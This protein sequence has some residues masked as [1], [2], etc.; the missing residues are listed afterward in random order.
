LPHWLR[1]EQQVTCAQLLPIL[2]RFHCAMLADPVGSG[3]TWVALG[4]AAV[5][6]GGHPTVALVPAGIQSQWVSAAA[7]AGVPLTVWSHERLS[8]GSLPSEL[9]HRVPGALVIVDESH[10]FRNGSTR[11]YRH[12]A[13][14]LMERTVLLLTATPMVNRIQD[15]TAQLALGARDDALGDWGIESLRTHLADE[16]TRSSSLSELI[17]ASQ[18]SPA[19]RPRRLRRKEPA[20]PDDRELLSRCERIDRLALS[21][22]NAT[23]ALIR[24]IIWRALASSDLALLG[25][26]R[27]YRTL[28]HQARDAAL[29]GRV[30]SRASLKSLVG[31]AED[32]LV[33]WGLFPQPVDDS[34]LIM[35]DLELLDQLIDETRRMA[36]SGDAKSRR[37]AALVGDGKSTVVFTG[38]RE[39][40]HYLR[41]QIPR[42]A[43]CTG[44]AA[45]I[46]FS[47][48]ARE[49]VL[50]W[51]RPGAPAPGLP[52][53]TVLL[54][55]DVTSEG[56]DLQRTCRVVHYDLPWTAVRIDQRDGRALRLGSE[57]ETVEVVRFEL[58]SAIEERLGHLGLVARKRRLPRKAGMD[59][60]GTRL[61]SWREDVARR[62]GTPATQPG[63]LY[64]RV[65]SSSAGMLAGFSLESG[66]RTGGRIAT[67]VGYL[68]EE[69]DW[70]EDPGVVQGMMGRALQ[71]SAL[72]PTSELAPDARGAIADV[73][74]GRLRSAT[75]AQ[76]ASHLTPLQ[77]AGIARLNRIASRAVRSRNS[78]LLAKTERAIAYF[79][80]GHTAGEEIWLEGLLGLSDPELIR[81]IGQ[82]PATI[83]REKILYPRLLG[84]VVFMPRRIFLPCQRNASVPC[85]S[86]SMEPSST[87]SG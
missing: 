28:L 52:G 4:V 27:R 42:A 73:L 10:H 60:H 81:E 44:S 20:P 38:A 15:L 77:S 67:I 65:E 48:M 87:R 69:G 37:L 56:L 63:P 70:S 11:R 14:S 6:R 24:C 22:N 39:T 21:R 41:E 34:D 80:E 55:T 45:G 47:T 53:P 79:R 50:S 17:V 9:L 36:G 57:H 35:E 49:D 12:L 72:E 58:P 3:K 1:P 8:R 26:L 43:W 68:D 13:P 5:W 84:L 59:S 61:W 40:V 25:V 46:G 62:F 75:L 19:G 30:F 78:S 18:G 2:E 54:T 29:S 64:C 83:R 76:W 85:S 86:I 74:Q 7:T 31:E 16:G 51:F 32:Q 33:M 66:G 82:C 71:D 23:A